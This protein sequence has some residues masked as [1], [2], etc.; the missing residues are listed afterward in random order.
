MTIVQ[1]SQIPAANSQNPRPGFPTAPISVLIVDDQELVR[2]HCQRVV[3]SLGFSA[4]QAGTAG[5]ALDVIE[6]QTVDIV[7]ADLKLPGMSGIELLEVLKRRNPRIEV[8]I[9]T[10]YSSV[11][12]AVQAMKLGAADYIVKPFG[13]E[14]L[15]Q[16]LR[17]LSEKQ[18]LGDENLSLREQLRSQHALG[19]LIGQSQPMQQIFKMIQRAAPSHASVLILGESGTGKELVARSIHDAGPAPNKPFTPVDCGALVPTLIESE[20]FGYVRGAFTGANTNKPG[21]LEAA[22]D[23]TL[24]LDEIGELPIELQTRLLRV[25]QEKEFRP[26]GGTRRFPFD[27]RIIAATNRDI[28][29]AVR[30]GAFRK[31]LYFRLNV[32]TIAL[33]PLRERKGDI[34]LLCEQMIQKLSSRPGAQPARSPWSLSSAALDRLLAYSWPGNVRELENVLERAMTLGSGPMIDL[35]DLPANVRSPLGLGLGLAD[36]S[37]RVVPLEQLEKSAILRALT[38]ADGD[39]ILA[40]R[41]LGI[42]KTTLY[43]KLRQYGAA[44]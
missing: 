20:L 4:P 19:K 22:R 24:F 37:G 28:E 26:I 17:K 21:L 25:I 43:R 38:E 41:M 23:G 40:A 8:V 35:A 27:A 36:D 3:E 31:D 6:R 34:P 12:S 13:S 10:G 29:A 39:K 2:K 44:V 42:G 32:V 5:A 30:S 1:H 11:S 33:P 15:G 7:L 18:Q 16:L 9:M 14:E